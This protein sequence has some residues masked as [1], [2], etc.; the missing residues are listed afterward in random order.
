VALIDVLRGRFLTPF[1]WAGILLV[2]S[3]C[4]LVPLRSI[5][6]LRLSAYLNRTSVWMLTAALGTVGYTFLDKIAAEVVQQGADTAARYGYF[7]F[8]ISFIPYWGFM[9]LTQPPVQRKQSNDWLLAL[10]ASIFG[11]GA[12]WLILWAYQL[13]PYASYIVAFRQFSIVIGAVIAFIVLKE[14]GVKVR[15]VGAGMITFGLVLIAGW[16]R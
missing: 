10:V 5:S 14:P 16:G 6:D 15:L 8:L 4:T 13:S 3:G 12:Y 7:Y 2:V 9:R 11:F 1:G